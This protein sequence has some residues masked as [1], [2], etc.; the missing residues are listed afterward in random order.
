LL[1]VRLLESHISG[2]RYLWE[3]DITKPSRLRVATFYFPGWVLRV[4]GEIQPTQ[5][6]NPYGLIDFSLSIGTHTV[7][8]TF[9]HT[10]LRIWAK[11]ISLVSLALLL[12]T[13]MWIFTNTENRRR[14][15]IIPPHSEAHSTKKK[16]H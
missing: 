8:T 1:L 16:Q 5:V 3:L 6:N 7:E 4:D 14:L 12:L 9:S 15:A 10:P 2:T 13:S 11:G